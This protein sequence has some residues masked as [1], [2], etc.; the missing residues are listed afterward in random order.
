[1]AKINQQDVLD[2]LRLVRDPVRG[3]DIVALGMVSGV[4]VRKMALKRVTHH[5]VISSYTTSA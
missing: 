1:M 3:A 4:L 2:R 5:S